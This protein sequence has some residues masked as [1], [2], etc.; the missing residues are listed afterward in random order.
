[1]SS[2]VA[3]RASI[4]PRLRRDRK[5]ALRLRQKQRVA[6]PGGGIGGVVGGW[7]HI[8]VSGENEWL[9]QR[10]KISYVRDE[11]IHEGEL[12]GVFFGLRRVAVRQIDRGDADNALAVRDDRL[13][14]ARLLVI[15]VAGKPPRD[16]DRRLGKDSDAIK[17]FL[18]VHGGIIAF[19]LDIQMRKHR[20][21]A[22]QLLQTED[23]RLGV[24]EI[25]QK[26]FG[27]LAHGIDVPRRDF[28]SKYSSI[29]VLTYAGTCR[30]TPRRARKA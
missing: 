10:Q 23:I 1:M 28:H 17:T 16:F 29:P 27:P 8:V 30:L 2:V 3:R 15:R 6:L 22:F 21:D 25:A 5:R 13:D 4:R 18:P 9:L 7:N 26:M 14:I 24:A 19:R 11:A 12:I 20:V